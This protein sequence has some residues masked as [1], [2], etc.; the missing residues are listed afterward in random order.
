GEGQYI[1]MALLDVQVALLANMNTNFL[2]SGK[3]PVRW[4]NAHP[5]IVPYQTFQTRDGWII[6]AVG[7]DGQFRK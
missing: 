1:D 2:A 5:N 6:V 3:P 7:N 4:G